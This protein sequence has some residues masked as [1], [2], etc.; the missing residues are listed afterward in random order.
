MARRTGWAKLSP[1]SRDR[2]VS[3]GRRGRLAPGDSLD[4]EQSREYW[5][6]G[7]D[8]S[9]AYGHKRRNPTAAP[10]EAT[11]RASSGLDTSED[12][13]ALDKWRRSRRAPD[14][15]PR[16]RAV[17]G[18]ET[19][20]ALSQIDLSPSRW[21]DVS[22]ELDPASG[23]FKM[24]VSP[25]GRGPDRV[26]YLQ[27]REALHDVTSLIRNPVP[28]GTTKAQKKKLEGQWQKVHIRVNATG[29]DAKKKPPSP[30]EP[31][32]IPSSESSPKPLRPTTTTGTGPTRPT[33]AAKKKPAKKKPAKKKPAKKKP[34]K[35]KPAKKKLATR[36]PIRK[37]PRAVPVPSVL[38]QIGD[39][40]TDVQE[41]S[42][43]QVEAIRK[44]LEG[45]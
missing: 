33:G 1:A 38:E 32:R 16:S 22:F 35:K 39:L 5:E 26:V 24:T 6:A 44:I 2:L 36:T 4:A 3:A 34:A 15:I 27:N 41:L 30:E 42:V 29:T 9:T 19:A 25:K 40:F 28:E 17:M 13:A 45:G 10:I 7:G 20:A 43:E 37:A 21:R 14:W 11:A 31:S 18:D 23:R 8:T 12:K